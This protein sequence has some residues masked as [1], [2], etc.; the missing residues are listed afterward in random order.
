[1][2]LD[3]GGLFSTVGVITRNKGIRKSPATILA[4]RRGIYHFK[5]LPES[6]QCIF[7]GRSDKLA[8]HHVLP[9]AIFPEFAED[10]DNLVALC[11]KRGCH[12]VVGHLGDFGGSFCPNI[13]DWRTE[14]LIYVFIDGI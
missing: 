2:S 9:V 1:M 7:C 8:Q 4:A 11:S 12:R 3:L 13:K 6:K 14:P 5:K 10:M